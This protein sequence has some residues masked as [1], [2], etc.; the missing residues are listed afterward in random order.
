MG[1]SLGRGEARLGKARLGM[2]G[3]GMK[4]GALQSNLEVTYEQ[5]GNQPLAP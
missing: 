3:R 4:Y 5:N 1:R 2:A